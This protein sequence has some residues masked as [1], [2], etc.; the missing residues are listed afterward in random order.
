MV[1]WSG[2]HLSRLGGSTTGTDFNYDVFSVIEHELDEILGSA[3]CEDLGT[4][5]LTNSCGGA[6]SAVDLFRYR[7]P[8][9]RAFSS[10]SPTTQYFLP[11][12]GVTDTDGATYNTVKPGEDWADFSQSCQFVQDAEG[13]RNLR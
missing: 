13:C 7:S 12:G 4:S 9:V 8:G 11:N 5:G 10:T 3:S 1:W 6:P 2:I